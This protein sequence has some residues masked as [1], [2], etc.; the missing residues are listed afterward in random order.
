[1]KGY[2]CT[3]ASDSFQETYSA[4]LIKAM[5]LLMNDDVLGAEKAVEGK[6]SSYHKVPLPKIFHYR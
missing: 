2:F 3:C 5:D 1:M 4:N 6:N